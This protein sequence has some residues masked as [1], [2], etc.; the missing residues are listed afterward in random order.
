MNGYIRAIKTT[1]NTNMS[2]Y[3]IIFLV[4]SGNLSYSFEY[5]AGLNGFDNHPNKVGFNWSLQSYN[6]SYHAN[7]I[8]DAV[9]KRNAITKLCILDLGLGNQYTINT[10]KEK[11]KHLIF[12]YNGAPN[13]PPPI[14]I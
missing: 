8:Y 11:T 3:L 7:K 2:T 5:L 6:T 4:F 14:K 12:K 13:N 9:P 10:N 1:I